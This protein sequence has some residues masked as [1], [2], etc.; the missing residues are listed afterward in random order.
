MP[1]RSADLSEQALA[2]SLSNFETNLE[3]VRR[4]RAEAGRKLGD[5]SDA[6]AAA[7]RKR[8]MAYGQQGNLLAKKEVSR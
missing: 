1:E 8:T 4:G 5:E 3:T 2:E 6:L 7:E